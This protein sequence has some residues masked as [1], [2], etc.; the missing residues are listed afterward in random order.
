M[1]AKFRDPK[2]PDD[3]LDFK[4]NWI[5]ALGGDTIIASAWTMPNGVTKSADSFT[6][7]T[8]T[9]WVSGGTARTSYNLVNAVTTAGGRVI[10]RTV[11]LGVAET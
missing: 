6:D 1:P 5:A 3:T 8:T 11:Q 4:V 10:S 9:V 7:T 2:G